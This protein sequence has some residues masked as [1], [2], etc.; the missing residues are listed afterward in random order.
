MARD[1]DE[2]SEVA[3]FLQ[4]LDHDIREHPERLRGMPK[5]LY[6][7]LLAVTEGL[8]GNPGDP[9]EGPVPL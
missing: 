7:R 9:I 8:E 6:Q 5:G 1:R 3:A 2:E 4:I